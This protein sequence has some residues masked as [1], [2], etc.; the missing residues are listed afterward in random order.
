[1]KRNIGGKVL[2]YE[3]IMKYCRKNKISLSAFEKK[4]GLG[5][6]TIKGWM[7]SSPR[8]D[9]LIKVAKEMGVSVGKLLDSELE[10]TCS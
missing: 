4:C 9:S 1:M 8:V 7:T 3:K 5:N 6:G 10:K 2:L